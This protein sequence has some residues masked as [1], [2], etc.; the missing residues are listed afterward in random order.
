MAEFEAS[1]D[2]LDKIYTQLNTSIAQK[3]GWGEKVKDKNAGKVWQDTDGVYRRLEIFNKVGK[4]KE[5]FP[6]N[7]Q[8]VS[9]HMHDA[10]IE[11]SLV[12]PKLLFALTARNR[13]TAAVKSIWEFVE[14]ESVKMT[15][16]FTISTGSELQV[17]TEE[18]VNFGIVES[19]LSMSAKL[20]L[21][22]SSQQQ[23]TV[24]KSI[25]ASYK[26]ELEPG[27]QVEATVSLFGYPIDGGFRIRYE[28]FHGTFDFGMRLNRDHIPPPAKSLSD[29][30]QYRNMSIPEFLGPDF[31]VE[32]KGITKGTTG[33]YSEF[34]TIDIDSIDIDS[35]VRAR[36][37]ASRIGS[38]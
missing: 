29:F 2:L 36:H 26:I 3:W 37:A 7:P 15:D 35:S 25:K 6:W 11:S 16:S 1:D 14:E 33:Y 5:K 22:T 34:D 18:E 12:P 17:G 27:A 4:L 9:L 19:K 8:G 30:T 13:N 32:I 24:E 38:G 21:N 28:V 20:N 10:S 23:R 31:L